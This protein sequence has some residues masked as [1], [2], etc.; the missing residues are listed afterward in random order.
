VAS[1]KIF[2]LSSWQISLLC[3]DSVYALA[4]KQL[5]QLLNRCDIALRWTLIFIFIVALCHRPY[6]GTVNDT[7]CPKADVPLTG[8]DEDTLTLV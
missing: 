6:R 5:S 3:E 2:S 1:C 7:V 4:R 8:M